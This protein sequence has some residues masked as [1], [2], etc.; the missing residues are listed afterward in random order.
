MVADI[1]WGGDC[2]AIRS[3]LGVVQL[4]WC[5]LISPL[6]NWVKIKIFLLIIL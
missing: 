3:P 4:H 6:L 1:E 2:F 5:R